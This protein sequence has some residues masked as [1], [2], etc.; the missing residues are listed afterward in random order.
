MKDDTD[1]TES[2]WDN[3]YEEETDVA[4]WS[5]PRR[6]GF[7]EWATEHIRET[8]CT[9]LDL[10]SGYGFGLQHA[11]SE[12]AGWQ[13]YGADFSGYAVE[14][15]VIPTVKLDL[16]NDP[17]PWG[18]D[19]LLCI[20]TLEHFRNPGEILERVLFARKKQVIITVPYREDIANHTQHVCS[21]DEKFF[22]EFGT[23]YFSYRYSRLKVVYGLTWLDE[24]SLR[25]PRTLVGL[26]SQ[27]RA[28]LGKLLQ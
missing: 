23:P 10:G 20:Q 22:L 11:C 15:A 14:N 2:Y 5:T 21:F 12:S 1:N 4:R 28:K 25:V 26:K 13:P 7:Y 9:L 16:L 27:L 6:L 19:Y 3:F 17:V 18:Y 8:D 24:V